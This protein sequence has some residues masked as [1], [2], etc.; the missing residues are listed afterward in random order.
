MTFEQ[1]CVYDL[2]VKNFPACALIPL[3]IA[4][5]SRFLHPRILA[6]QP[7]GLRSAYNVL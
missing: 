1:K 2:F 6:R 5:A 3:E 7:L 4:Y